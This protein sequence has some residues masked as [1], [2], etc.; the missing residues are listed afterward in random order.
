MRERDLIERA[1]E[2]FRAGLD[3]MDRAID[4]LERR[5]ALSGP[6]R[7]ARA[8]EAAARALCRMAL[9]DLFGTT[10]PEEIEADWRRYLKK[11]RTVLMAAA[12]A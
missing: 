1:R 3:D 4:A 2:R 6:E 5:A 7:L 10:T 12:A 11:A 8:E 9:E